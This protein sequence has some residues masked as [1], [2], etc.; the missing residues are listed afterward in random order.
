[1]QQ[2]NYTAWVANTPVAF[3]FTNAK[4][5]VKYRLNVSANAGGARLALAKLVLQSNPVRHVN[6]DFNQDGKTDIAVWRPSTGQWL[7]R[8]SSTGN[9]VSVFW[10]GQWA[11]KPV[12]GDY[13]GDGKTDLAL[14]NPNSG[15]WNI[16]YSG[17]SPD[18]VIQWGTNGDIPVPAMYTH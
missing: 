17:G 10:G 15:N 3:K 14:W 16:H 18:A 13:D 11:G 12:V 7:I 2:S 6:V 8:Q 9:V 4:A 1:M 5:Y